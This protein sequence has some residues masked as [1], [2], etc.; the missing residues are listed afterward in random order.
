[1]NSRRRLRNHVFV[2]DRKFATRQEQA[3]RKEDI[4]I[5]REP[6]ET[7]LDAFFQ[8]HKSRLDPPQYNYIALRKFL[9]DARENDIVRPSPFYGQ[10]QQLALVNDRRDITAWVDVAGNRKSACAWDGYSKYPP[11]G[12]NV[13]LETL[14]AHE[15]YTRLKM[16]VRSCRAFKSISFG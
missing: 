11:Q 2:W 1:M 16:S 14:N 13:W 7:A 8:V 4:E 12:E 5:E 15:L 6:H 3:Y 10:Q 9:A